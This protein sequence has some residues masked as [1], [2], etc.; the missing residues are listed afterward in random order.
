[1]ITLELQWEHKDE[2]IFIDYAHNNKVC[3]VPK[4]SP[5]MLEQRTLIFFDDE[6]RVSNESDLFNSFILGDNLFVL[7][8]LNKTFE[9]YSEKQKVKFV[10]IDPP[11]NT[12]NPELSYKDSLGHEEWLSF[13]NDRLER[14]KQILRPDGVICVQIDD[15]EYA[16]LYLLMIELFGER[17]LKTIVVKMSE[18]SGLKMQ[19]SKT[20]GIPK[21]KEYLILAK[22]DGTQGF[23]F[24]SIPKESWDPEYNIFVKNITLEDREKIQS[25]MN[26][27]KTITSKEITEIDG[28]CKKLELVN[29]NK[30]IEEENISNELKINFLK[31]NS[32]R[33]CRTAASKSVY[34]LTEHKKK[35]IESKQHVF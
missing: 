1:M 4:D 8:I 9:R 22:M 16:R 11:Y 3:W 32:W 27:T 15:R 14:I 5:I 34:T 10:Y 29:I 12:F 6:K 28:I 25:Y 13:M 24:E 2:S 26:D 17:N 30:V 18:A 33:I 23:T 19:V 7:N 20:G 21:L 31:M 35:I